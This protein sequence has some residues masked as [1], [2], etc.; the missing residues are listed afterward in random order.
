M[1]TLADLTIAAHVIFKSVYSL[2]A[3]RHG[4]IAVKVVFPAIDGGK[5][6]SDF[7]EKTER[8]TIK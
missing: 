4:A 5:T 1:E 6:L 7:I 3:G 2:P 8:L